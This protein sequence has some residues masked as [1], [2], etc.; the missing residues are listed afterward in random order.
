MEKISEIRPSPIA[1]LWYTNNQRALTLE[2]EDYFAAV[3]LPELAGEI[4]GLIAPHAGYRYSGR[5]AAH[6]YKS[7]LGQKRDL[8]VVISPLHSYHPATL[9]TSAHQAYATPLGAVDIDKDAVRQLN[10]ILQAESQLTL[11]EISND[12]EHSLE[13]ELP[14][15]Q[16]ALEGTFKLLPVMV[17]R[18]D[19]RIIRD[20]G[21]ALAKI[22]SGRSYLLVA[23]TD[24]SHFYPL[25]HAQQFDSAM[26]RQIEAFSPEGVLA[27]EEQK[28]GFA[29]GAGAVAAVLHAAR[30]LGGNHVDIVHYSTSASETGDPHSVVGY[31]AAVITKQA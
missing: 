20:L 1:G 19:E 8:V 25:T 5:T 16:R 22:L 21:R 4:I 12:D 3:I 26:L 27:A 9:L 23:S 28:S 24:L 14:F 31:G 6:A 18:K 29:C 10:H 11:T 17:R 30:L 13:I 2:I 15:L 7:V